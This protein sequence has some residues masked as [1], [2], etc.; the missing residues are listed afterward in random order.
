MEI[1][2]ADG[3]EMLKLWGYGEGARPSPTARYFYENIAGG[4]A[5]FW[6]LDRNGALLG[7]LYAF[8]D[9]KEDRDFADGKDTAYL[10][11]FRIRP[12]Y[13]G[14][15]LG[16]RLMEA[17]LADLKARGFRWASIGVD[18][19][20]NERLYRRMG[21]TEAVKICRFD[22]CAR[23]AEMRPEAVEGGFLLLKKAL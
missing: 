17:V 9:I 8:L 16:T 5:D 4:N 3:G 11:A 7:E 15:G 2:K 13:R 14:Q 21:F 1:R 20:R 18:D 22:P 23:D 19:G 6:T 10:C 12:E